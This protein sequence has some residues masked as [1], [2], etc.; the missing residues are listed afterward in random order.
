MI[1]QSVR[2]NLNRHG[3]PCF[4][5]VVTRY[6]WQEEGVLGI[7][8]RRW[9]LPRRVLIH[10]MSQVYSYEPKWGVNFDSFSLR[11]NKSPSSL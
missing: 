6:C 1:A 7:M 5:R 9:W 8:E 3:P 2:L 10:T 11:L 4:P